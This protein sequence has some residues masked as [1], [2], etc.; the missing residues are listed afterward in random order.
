MTIHKTIRDSPADGIRSNSDISFG[1][2]SLFYVDIKPTYTNLSQDNHR[3]F[4]LTKIYYGR[5]PSRR[6][7]FCLPTRIKAFP[8]SRT[9]IES[10]WCADVMRCSNK[11][12]SLQ[13]TSSF[14]GI[15]CREFD[16]DLSTQTQGHFS[17]FRPAPRLSRNDSLMC[18]SH[19][20]TSYLLTPI[21]YFY[22]RLRDNFRIVLECKSSLRNKSYNKSTRQLSKYFSNNNHCIQ[23]CQLYY[24]RQ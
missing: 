1:Y 5:R 3:Y 4:V 2:K 11:H 16:R 9:N 18:F 10:S 22:L 13:Y 20:L 21:Y 7:L 8:S 14:A 12:F 17:D 15:E 23:C 19:D 6:L 24:A